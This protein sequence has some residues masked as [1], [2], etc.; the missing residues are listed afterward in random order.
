MR[1]KE[2]GGELEGSGGPQCL[3]TEVCQE[4]A[5]EDEVIKVNKGE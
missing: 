3:C 2:V 5:E 4:G 1:W